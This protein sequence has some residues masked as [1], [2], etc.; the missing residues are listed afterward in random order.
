MVRILLIALLAFSVV[1][2]VPLMGTS[3]SHSLH[4]GASASCATC[5]GSEVSSDVV[6]L[7]TLLGLLA[8]VITVAPPFALV[9]NQ[10]H[11]PRIL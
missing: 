2:M 7:L 11:P 5:M 1:C 4:H 10:F 8:V 3:D 9:K 6:F